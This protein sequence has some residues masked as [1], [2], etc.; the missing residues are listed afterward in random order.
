MILS[1]LEA[2][3]ALAR[4]VGFPDGRVDLY[5]GLGAGVTI[6]YTR[7]LMD[8][9]ARGQYGWGRLATQVL[10]ASRGTCHHAGTLR[11]STSSPAP[12]STARSQRVIVDHGFTPIIWRSDSATTFKA[13]PD[14]QTPRYREVAG[15]IGLLAL[16]FGMIRS[17]VDLVPQVDTVLVSTCSSTGKA[18]SSRW[19]RR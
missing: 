8:G 19:R 14:P 7:S 4:T 1:N 18:R 15:A 2:H 3:K 16:N 17:A 13:A 5:S 11:Q 6:P 9:E 12:R 10:G